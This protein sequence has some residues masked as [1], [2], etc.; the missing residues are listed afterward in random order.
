MNNNASRKEWFKVAILAVG[1][2]VGAIIYM[3]FRYS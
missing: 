1:V 3:L 2:T